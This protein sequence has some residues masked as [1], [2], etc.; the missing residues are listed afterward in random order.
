VNVEFYRPEPHPPK[1]PYEYVTYTHIHPT[2]KGGR[3]HVLFRGHDCWCEPTMS[4]VFDVDG[5][6]LV[7]IVVIHNLWT[8]PDGPGEKKAAYPKLRTDK[9]EL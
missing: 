1:F 8:N 2:F 7:A 5:K 3:Q 4:Q 6:K 9:N